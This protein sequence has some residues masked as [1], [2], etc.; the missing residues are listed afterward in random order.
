MGT[1]F[2]SIVK[3]KYLKHLDPDLQI[4]ITPKISLY[5]RIINSELKKKHHVTLAKVWLS[6]STGRQDCYR[7]LVFILE[8]P[9]QIS[10]LWRHISSIKKLSDSP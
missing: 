5:D 6:H 4:Q 2:A 1:A 8:T 3:I 7:S 9:E 10:S